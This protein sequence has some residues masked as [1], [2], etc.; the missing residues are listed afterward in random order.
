MYIKIFS[1][2]KSST[3]LESLFEGDDSVSLSL[4]LTLSL[5]LSLTH[6]LTLSVTIRDRRLDK[7]DISILNMFQTRELTIK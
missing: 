7:N 2:V 4:S 3:G 1:F 5:S 6:T